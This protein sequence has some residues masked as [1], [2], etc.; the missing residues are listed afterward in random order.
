M[1]QYVFNWSLP[2]AIT[3]KSLMICFQFW[4]L[5]TLTLSARAPTLESDVCGRQILTAKVDTR[6][7]R[8]KHLDLRQF[9]LF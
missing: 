8:I 2:C 9:G 1:N 3:S 4:P 6:T 5:N 7:E